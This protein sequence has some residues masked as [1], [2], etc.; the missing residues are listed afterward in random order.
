MGSQDEQANLATNIVNGALQNIANY[1]T[2]TC[3]DNISNLSFTIIGGNNTINIGQACSIVG[4]ECMVK[5]IISSHVTNLVKNIVDQSESNLGIFSLYGP[6][7]SETTNITNAI[8]NQVSQLIANTCSVTD[9][10]NISNVS[11]FA[12]DANLN[13]TISQV[14]NIQN[15][16]CAL[17]TTAKLLINNDVAN[18]VKQSESSC[19]DILAILIV[20]AILAILFIFY[21]LLRGAASA[22]GSVLTAGGSAAG[23]AIGAGG[24]VVG[25]GGNLF[26]RSGANSNATS[27]INLNGLQGAGG[28]AT[29]SPGNPF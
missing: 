13:L 11:V 2:I 29:K 8:K 14:G 15:S 5:N 20:V 3:E 9:T 4:S 6:S 25:A 27:T 10:K 18:S 12:Q 24:N 7:S 28:G 1:C 26:S 21:P 22:G 19:G 17:D 23:K 16:Q